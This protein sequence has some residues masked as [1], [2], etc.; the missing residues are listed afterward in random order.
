MCP[1]LT[2]LH[3]VFPCHPGTSCN[4]KRFEE[5][6]KSP[7]SPYFLRFFE[8]KI[9]LLRD[10]KVVGSNPVAPTNKRDHPTDGLFYCFFGKGG[11]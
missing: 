7:K 6:R 1:F 5:S 9:S 4:T 8:R 3:G 10:Q 11:I 2:V